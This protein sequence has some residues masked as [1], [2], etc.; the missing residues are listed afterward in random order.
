MLEEY[1]ETDSTIHFQ[2][3]NSIFINF[4]VFKKKILTLQFN[5][6]TATVVSN[7]AL[8]SPGVS[9]TDKLN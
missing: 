4:I 8:S 2:L 1:P 3:M 6:G 9:D 5:F 7:I